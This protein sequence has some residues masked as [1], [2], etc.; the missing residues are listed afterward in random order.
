MIATFKR[1]VPHFAKHIDDEGMDAMVPVN[2][3]EDNE[4]YNVF[5][6]CRYEVKLED[7][8]QAMMAEKKNEAATLLQM[9]LSTPV[10]A[11]KDWDPPNVHERIEEIKDYNATLQLNEIIS[12]LPE[13]VQQQVIQQISQLGQQI[14]EQGKEKPE[15]AR[16]ADQRVATSAGANDTSKDRATSDI[17]N[18]EAKV[19]AANASVGIQ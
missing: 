16:S 9:G 13:E 14:E 6:L 11:L 8:V 4:M 7:N 2:T 18:E 1:G 17:E 10:R 15:G 12:Q 5:R 19:N 3:E